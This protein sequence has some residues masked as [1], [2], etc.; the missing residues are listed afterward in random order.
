MF[1]LPMRNCF[2]F[3]TKFRKRKVR[4]IDLREWWSSLTSGS[5]GDSGTL[6]CLLYS[7]DSTFG[8]RQTRFFILIIVKHVMH[9]CFLSVFYLF[10][11]FVFFLSLTR[12][13]SSFDLL[14]FCIVGQTSMLFS[15]SLFSFDFLFFFWFPR[16]FT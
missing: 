11:R 1:N 12:S 15:Q 6:L 16:I 2:F 4:R 14:V 7:L 8:M 10:I 9:A 13:I 3:F 5:G